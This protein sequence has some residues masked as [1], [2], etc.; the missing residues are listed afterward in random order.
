VEH[1]LDQSRLAR[2]RDAVT[3]AGRLSRMLVTEETRVRIP[4]SGHSRP[5][6]SGQ[7]ATLTEASRVFELNVW[8]REANQALPGQEP[9]SDRTALFSRK[10]TV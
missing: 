2:A 5:A 6:P 4:K 1:S 8:T 10:R 3:H 9:P 7:Q